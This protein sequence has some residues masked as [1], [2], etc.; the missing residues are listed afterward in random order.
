[1]ILNYAKFKLKSPSE[2]NSELFLLEKSVESVDPKQAK[3]FLR[4]VF[5]DQTQDFYL[6][7]R[8]LQLTGYLT[9]IN[10]IKPEWL[11]ALIVDIEETDNEFIVAA[12]LKLASNLIHISKTSILSWAQGLALCNNAEIR[13]EAFL[14]LGR[15]NLFEALSADSIAAFIANLDE[16]KGYFDKSSSEI[17][18]RIDATMFSDI[19][20]FLLKVKTQSNYPINDVYVRLRANLWDYV[21]FNTHEA[22]MLFFVN[23]CHPISVLHQI[24]LSTPDNWINFR[25]ELNTLLQE[26]LKLDVKVLTN[27]LVQQSLL[28]QYNLAIKE[29]LVMGF[30]SNKLADHILRLKRI[31]DEMLLDS[32]EQMNLLEELL[33]YL[34]LTADKKKDISNITEIVSRL[35]GAFPHVPLTKV[36]QDIQKID[37]TNALDVVR[38]FEQYTY[39]YRQI[40]P[41]EFE[42]GYPQGDEILKMIVDEI[43]MHL[44]SYDHDKLL[45]F[46]LVLRDAV[47][48]FVTASRA[49]I[50]RMPFLFKSNAL[51]IDLQNSMLVFFNTSKRAD[52]YIP[53]VVEAADGGRVDI[54]FKGQRLQLPIELKKS[55]QILDW[56]TVKNNYIS[57]AQTYAHTRDQLA[58]F[59]VLDLSE[60]TPQQPSPN[61]RDLFKIIH[62]NSEHKFNENFPDYVVS[63]IISANKLSPHKRS[64]YK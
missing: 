47:N 22:D 3:A 61:I 46:M 25:V 7:K 2:K 38:M 12:A 57:Q 63:F 30:L 20:F 4:E 62:L 29:K 42:T 11:I 8:A 32:T 35:H 64:K 52:Q 60:K 36:T 14:L 6:R 15:N 53:E 13:S 5:C 16:A 45:E 56:E 9:L 17:E 54:L 1:M 19:T 41:S 50:K 33:E 44:P 39:Q 43:R 55:R 28:D 51:E 24:A 59:F 48:Y 40:A 58:F 23:I 26:L 21:G 27:N 10:R 34:L 37:S 31:K 49:S 18:N